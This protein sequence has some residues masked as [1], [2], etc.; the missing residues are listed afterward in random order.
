MPLQAKFTPHNGLSRPSSC[1]STGPAPPG[2]FQPSSCLSCPAQRWELLPH[3][4]LSGSRSS[5]TPA[6]W[7]PAH[8][9]RG[10]SRP[11]PCMWAGSPVPASTS[12][13]A[14][15]GP[16]SCLAVAPL[17]QPPALRGALQAQLLPPSGHCR[18]SSCL[19]G[20]LP[21]PRFCFWWPLQA[22]NLTSSRP[23][24]AWLFLPVASAG[25]SHTQLLPPP[26]GL[27]AQPSS[28]LLVAFPGPTF[29]SW[30]PLQAP[31]LTSCQPLRVQPPASRRPVYRISFCLTVHSPTPRLRSCLPAASIGPVPASRWPPQ[32]QLT[33]HNGLSAP[34]LSAFGGLS[35]PVEAHSRPPSWRPLQA[36]PFPLLLAASTGL[37]AASQQAN[38]AHLL[39]PGGVHRPSSGWRTASAGPMLASQGPIQARL[40]PPGGFPRPGSCLPASQQPQQAQ[41]LPHRGLFW[42]NSCL[43]RPAQRY[44][45]LPHTGLS[46]LTSSLTLAHWG[47]TDASRGSPGLAPACGLPL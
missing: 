10:L 30:W 11:S 24:R 12:Q 27:F 35:R 42:P 36:Q 16:T 5:L 44:E 17:G 41:L 19:D 32:A 15:S 4:G 3:T 26:D 40:S 22:R 39:L 23:L 37:T 8:A 47:P 2:L 6:H 20:A 29:D 25:P 46:G 34:S 28:C 9:S 14:L 18:P 45:L 1:R 31:N 7:G 43:S 38:F 21:R 13:W 33:P